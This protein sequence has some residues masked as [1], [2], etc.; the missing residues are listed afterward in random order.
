MIYADLYE[1]AF[2]MCINS[3]E[4][5]QDGVLQWHVKEAASLSC[6]IKKV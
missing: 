3:M 4:F 1:K 5:G 2:K 6:L